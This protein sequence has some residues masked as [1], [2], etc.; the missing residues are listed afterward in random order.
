MLAPKVENLLKFLRAKLLQFYIHYLLDYKRTNS[1][2]LFII[3]CDLWWGFILMLPT[4]TFGASPA[5]HYLSELI[6]EGLLG[7]TF[8]GMGVTMFICTVKKP[9][10]YY[11][12]IVA[13]NTLLWF[14]ISYSFILSN[15]LSTG[16]GIYFLLSCTCGI[17]YLRLKDD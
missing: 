13:L 10:H 17:I 9:R 1:L 5:F 6:S 7:A 3:L 15:F 8:L 11:R 14:F 2:A 12:F 4:N 16:T